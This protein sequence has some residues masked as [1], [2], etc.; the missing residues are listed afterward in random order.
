[1]L[2]QLL[3]CCQRIFDL[4]ACASDRVELVR[5]VGRGQLN[6]KLIEMNEL[7]ADNLPTEE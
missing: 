7:A 4:H 1:M 2:L 3:M 6:V 5:A